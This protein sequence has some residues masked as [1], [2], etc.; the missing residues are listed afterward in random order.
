MFCMRTF[1]REGGLRLI[2][3][4]KFSGEAH[5]SSVTVCLDGWD[6]NALLSGRP[7]LVPHE[8]ALPWQLVTAKRYLGTNSRW[9]L[10][11]SAFSS[12]VATHDYS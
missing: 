12:V 5:R 1:G 10:G 11:S 7:F 2:G 9:Q 3:R 8:S 4:R 6:V